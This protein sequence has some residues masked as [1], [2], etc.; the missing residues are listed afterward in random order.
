MAAS[1]D[2]FNCGY[3]FE[4]RAAVRQYKGVKLGAAAELPK[5]LRAKCDFTFYGI[6]TNASLAAFAF[7]AAFNRVAALSVAHVVPEHEFESKRARGQLT[8]AKG[9]CTTWLGLGIG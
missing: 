2:N 1:K 9:A 6:A 5:A 7:A 4:S 3:F 8:C